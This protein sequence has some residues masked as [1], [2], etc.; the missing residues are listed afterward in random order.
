MER[1]RERGVEKDREKEVESGGEREVEVGERDR[2]TL[3]DSAKEETDEMLNPGS[4]EFILALYRGE[5]RKQRLEVACG[6]VC[7]DVDV[8]DHLNSISVTAALLICAASLAKLSKA[9]LGAN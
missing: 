3:L 9:Y 5:G 6:C 2:E 1:D 4:L 7:V 8:K